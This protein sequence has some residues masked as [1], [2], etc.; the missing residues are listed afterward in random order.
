M[1]VNGIGKPSEFIC[2][3]A[4]ITGVKSLKAQASVNISADGS[5][6]DIKSGILF[7]REKTNVS[8]KHQLTQIY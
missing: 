4:T 7:L 5:K 8:K 3:P 6:S 1:E 2:D